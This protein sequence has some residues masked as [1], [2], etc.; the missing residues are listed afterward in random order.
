MGGNHDVVIVVCE[1][2]LLNLLALNIVCTAEV[3]INMLKFIPSEDVSRAKRHL[4]LFKVEGE[5]ALVLSLGEFIV[6]PRE[7]G[8]FELALEFT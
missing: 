3:A 2:K 8:V 4:L 1:D 5:H 6:L 7:V